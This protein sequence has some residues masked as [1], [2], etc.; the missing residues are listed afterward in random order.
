MEIIVSLQSLIPQSASRLLENLVYIELRRKAKEV[1]YHQ[2]G[3]RE[4]DFVVRDGFRVTKAIQV[5]H[6]FDFYGTRE[7]EIQGLTEAM[8]TYH[9]DEGL[10]VTAFHEEEIV[11]NGKRIHILPAWKWLKQ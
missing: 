3:N 11:Q 1:F 5:C 8:E 10:I 9:L 4:C 6:A 2:S 7:R